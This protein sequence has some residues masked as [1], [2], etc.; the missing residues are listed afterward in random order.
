MLFLRFLAQTFIFI[1]DDRFHLIISFRK[2]RK[3][4]S[5]DSVFNVVP[6]NLMYDGL[7]YS[8]NSYAI[9]YAKIQKST[10]EMATSKT[11]FIA[12][13]T[14]FGLWKRLIQSE[15]LH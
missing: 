2:F 8:M 14:Y 1:N 4:R 13:K 11:K 5:A 12:R 10:V 7:V 3:S 15:T 6:Y 9:S